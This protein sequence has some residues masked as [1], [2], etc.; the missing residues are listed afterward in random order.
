VSTDIDLK[1][2]LRRVVFLFDLHRF[3]S[4]AVGLFPPRHCFLIA[5]SLVHKGS[6][7][8]AELLP[9][10]L[11]AWAP[12]R[13]GEGR[14]AGCALS[15]LVPV[16]PLVDMMLAD[17]S[18]IVHDPRIDGA[19]CS[20]QFPFFLCQ[21]L[22]CSSTPLPA[23]SARVLHAHESSKQAMSARTHSAA[24]EQHTHRLSATGTQI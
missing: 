6:M 22:Q 21:R 15:R 13:G 18:A 19:S 11:R 20:Q 14:R 4:L 8:S 9:H 12:S 7:G 10:P 2:W 24:H 23:E 5:G 1:S 16:Q 3:V 17:D